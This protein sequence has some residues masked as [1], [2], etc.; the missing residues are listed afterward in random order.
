MDAHFKRAF[1]KEGR[2]HHS[3][4]NR[5]PPASG[6]DYNTRSPV[7]RVNYNGQVDNITDGGAWLPVPI[8]P[9][10]A[11]VS[12][13]PLVTV[14][15]AMTNNTRGGFDSPYARHLSAPPVLGYIAPASPGKLATPYNF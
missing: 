1:A 11:P 12:Y 3:G 7:D 14:A 10:R 4:V 15:G 6:I 13:N 9:P 8:A 2:I 5:G